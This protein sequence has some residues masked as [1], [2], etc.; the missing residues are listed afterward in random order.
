MDPDKLLLWL[1]RFL[2]TLMILVGLDLWIEATIEDKQT[3][4]FMVIFVLGLG[5]LTDKD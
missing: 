4:W 1:K 3:L 5:L 2:A